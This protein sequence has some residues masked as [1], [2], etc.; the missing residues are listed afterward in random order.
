MA[1]RAISGARRTWLVAELADWSRSG[2]ISPSQE[3]RILE[4]YETPAEMAMRSR[5]RALLTLMGLAAF[6][7]GLAALLL[8]AYNWELMPSALKLAIVFAVL[9]ITHGAGL[10]LRTR[11]GLAW[12]YRK[13]S[14]MALGLDVPLL[15]W[16]TILQPFAWG[17]QLVNPAYFV[18]AVGGLLL[19]V[20]E[21]QREQ[22]SMALPYRAYGTA[23]AAG[24][25]MVLSLYD[26][27][28][29]ERVV[30]HVAG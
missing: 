26:V 18:G 19:V 24:A 2:I 3:T 15:A 23:L 9:G 30:E 13:H 20:G 6:L 7:V 14:R 10:V 4:L 16:W 25:L 8:I 12:A 27:H 22:S 17:Y 29:R 21:L 28:K 11:P 5:S 1:G